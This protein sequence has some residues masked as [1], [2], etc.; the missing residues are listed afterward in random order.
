MGITLVLV[1]VEE[2][3][4]SLDSVAIGTEFPLLGGPE[5]LVSASVAPA[6][7]DPASST[8]AKAGIPRELPNRERFVRDA[9]SFICEK[10][11]FS[12]LPR[13]IWR[14]RIHLLREMTTMGVTVVAG[15]VL[16]VQE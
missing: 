11:T 15:L 1:V 13:S 8:A 2:S 10:V 14:N 6:Q 5:E 12:N 4:E 9:R 7:I 3:P 16:L